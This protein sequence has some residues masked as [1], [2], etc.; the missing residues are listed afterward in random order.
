[1]GSVRCQYSSSGPKISKEWCVSLN[2]RSQATGFIPRVRTFFQAEHVCCQLLSLSTGLPL[3]GSLATRGILCAWSGLSLLFH[4]LVQEGVGD[5]PDS[6][7]YDGNR[8]R[9]WN[10]T[11][12]NYGKVSSCPSGMG[13]RRRRRK[14]VTPDH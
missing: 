1:M 7:A 8:V 10:V 13:W 12:T 6:Y 14:Q 2:Q 5:T 11:T 9:K 4:T 3:K